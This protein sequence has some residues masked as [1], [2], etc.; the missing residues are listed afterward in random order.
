MGTGRSP[1]LFRVN[2][3]GAP[4]FQEQLQLWTWASLHSLGTGKSPYPSRLGSACSCCLASPCS[5]C[6][7]WDGAKLWP[8]MGTVVTWLGVHTL[9]M[10]L[11][12]QLPANSPLSKLWDQGALEGGQG[13]RVEGSSMWACRQPS[14]ETPRAPVDDMIGGSRR[15]TGSWVE[16]R[17]SPLKPHFQDRD[18]LQPQ[19]WAV[20][21]WWSSQW[22]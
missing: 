22:E 18:S 9:R 21:S 19:G 20:S 16:R 8:S 1:T 11:T 13:G 6:L 4:C 5:Q 3:V 17:R 2:E 12:C 15:Q 14:T 7:L 10:A